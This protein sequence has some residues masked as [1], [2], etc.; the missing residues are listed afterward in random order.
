MVLLRALTALEFSE[1]NTYVTNHLFVA[2]VLE[3]LK[4]LLVVWV[5]K[6]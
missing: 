5:S 4:Q 6:A 1:E 3:Q 2:V